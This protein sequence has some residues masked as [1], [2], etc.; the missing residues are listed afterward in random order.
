M[1][2]LP[3]IEVVPGRRV[4]NHLCNATE[5]LRVVDAKLG[6]ALDVFDASDD[7]RDD[8]LSLQRSDL[9]E[10][11]LASRFNA[12]ALQ[13]L[14][15]GMPTLPDRVFAAIRDYRN[16]SNRNVANVEGAIVGLWL[17]SSELWKA[18]EASHTDTDDV[19]DVYVTAISA[20]SAS[21]HHASL[22]EGIAAPVYPDEAIE[23]ILAGREPRREDLRAAF[24][25]GV[26]SQY[27]VPTA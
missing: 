10:A 16:I 27:R 23:F 2:F 19:D 20:R 15:E 6:E 12:W 1:K 11:M 17:A 4:Q 13:E 14:F 8:E 21:S 22:L 7:G 3:S 26:V 25:D 24:H 9:E 18:I 5:L